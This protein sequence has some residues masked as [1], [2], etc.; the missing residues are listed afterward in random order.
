MAQSSLVGIAADIVLIVVAGL[1]GGLLAQRLGQPLL[2]GYILAGVMVGPHTAGPTVV[3]I[4]DIEL[5]AEIGVA[6][7]LFALGLEVS[8]RDLRPVRRVALIG[9]PIQILLTAA[10][11]YGLGRTVL[12][13]GHE[14]ALWLGAMFSLSSTMVVIKILTAQGATRRLSSRVMIGILVVQDLAVAPLLIL[15]PKLGDLQNALPALAQAVFQGALFLG[16]MVF[17]GTRLIPVLLRKVAGLNSRELF[18][19]TIVALGVG[20]GYGTYLFGLSFALGA[21]VAGMV[22]SESEFSHQALSNIVPL[23]DIF[24]LLFFA[25][26]GMLLDLALLGTH[27]TQ[28]AVTMGLVLFFKASLIGLVVRAFGYSE[29]VPWAV[30][31]GLS[32]VGE[33]AF[34]LAR[35]GQKGGN[36][37]EEEY[38]L[39]LTVTLATMVLSPGLARLAEPLHGVWRR[40]RPVERPASVAHIPSE[41]LEGHVV[42]AGLGRSGRAAVEVMRQVGLPFVVIE[43]NHERAETARRQGLPVVWGDSSGE[44][45][46]EAAGVQKARL[47]LVA[48]ADLLAAWVRQYGVPKALYCDWKNVYQR[49]PTSREALEGIK[50][51]TQFGRMCTKLGIGI[52]AASSP[53]AKGRV[54][55]HHG[56]HQDRLIK[57]MRL[58]GIVDYE[59]ANRYLDEEYLAEHNERFCCEPAEGADFHQALPG[60]TD[61][62][63]VFCLEYERVVSNDQ[64]VR[65]ENRCLQLKPKRNQGVG[66]GARVTVQQWRDQSLHVRFE[67]HEIEH[68]VIATPTPQ[69]RTKPAPQG[70]VGA[71]R[72]PAANHPWRRAVLRKTRSANS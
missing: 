33:F 24:G 31:L 60:G 10:F 64:V 65:F 15:L 63:G 67:G 4:H 18:L 54:E 12:G 57:K 70:L 19:V 11:G 22:L 68:E 36:L 16:A 20:V 49:Q 53:Q 32:Q 5:L 55:R 17:L 72:K 21:F 62:R 37:T 39:A 27:F 52:I 30:G 1:L 2:V 69:L 23:R 61:L 34:V 48:A 29:M 40:Y 47:L 9:G 6:L 56:T 51:E 43:L 50:P 46:L 44:K 58:R 41:G 59:A 13:W 45:V 26:A 8:F 28:V 42:V 66:A 14:P 71:A 38:A 3:E 25:S 35:A 7:L